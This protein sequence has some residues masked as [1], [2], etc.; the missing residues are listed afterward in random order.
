MSIKKGL[1]FIAVTLLFRRIYDRLGSKSLSEKYFSDND[2]KFILEI[3]DIQAIVLLTFT[4]LSNIKTQ[5]L[6]PK[7]MDLHQ[8][9]IR[10]L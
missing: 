2:L 1:L 8:L 5:Y 3:L 9:P 6:C 7:G 10:G 4:F